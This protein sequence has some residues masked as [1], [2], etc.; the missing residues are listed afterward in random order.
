MD[1]IRSFL[2]IDFGSFYAEEIKAVIQS[3]KPH[4]AEVKWINSEA[5]HLTLSFFGAVEQAF[6]DTAGDILKKIAPRHPAFSLSLHG[7]GGFPD[8]SNPRVLWAGLAGQTDSLQALKQAIDAGLLKAGMVAPEERD[9][10]PH[11]TLGRLRGSNRQVRNL[12]PEV[13][14]FHSP[15][16]YRADRLIIFK[17]ELTREGARYTPL[18][19]FE[20]PPGNESNP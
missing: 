17:S 8:L 19:T 15:K 5:V 9:F 14:N 12:P 6:I 20:L 11:L 18:R 4:Y 13:L 16:N 7:V 3:L 10:R 1:K 2:A